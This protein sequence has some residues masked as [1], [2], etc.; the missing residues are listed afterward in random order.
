MPKPSKDPDIQQKIQHW[1][2]NNPDRW[3]TTTYKEIHAETGVSGASLSRYFPLIV[4]K[5]ANILP[6]EVKAKRYAEIGT[7]PVLLK[8]S[9]EEIATIRR[10]FDEG[11]S[12][13]D[14]AHETGRSLTQVERYKPRP[15]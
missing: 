9:D 10:L 5:V 12:P 3:Y 4:A 8:L 15:L 13:L 2:E 1:V 6:S 14:I 11:R 7:P